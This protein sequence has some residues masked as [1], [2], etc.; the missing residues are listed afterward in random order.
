MQVDN[1]YCKAFISDLRS[2]T[3]WNL[4]L[5]AMNETNH[6]VAMEAIDM[7]ESIYVDMPDKVTSE[8]H[9]EVTQ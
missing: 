5:G 1:R 4:R 9:I 8:D 7:L 2:C 6:K 3:E